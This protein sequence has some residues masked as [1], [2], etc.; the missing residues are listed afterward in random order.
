MSIFNFGGL[1]KDSERA[2]GYTLQG[3]LT[4]LAGGAQIRSLVRTYR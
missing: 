4:M 1:V 3:P 2:E